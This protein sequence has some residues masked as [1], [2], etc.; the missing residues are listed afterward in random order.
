MKLKRAWLFS[1]FAL[2][3]TAFAAPAPLLKVVVASPT[4]PSN[5]YSNSCTLDANGQVIIEHTTTLFP[6]G[7]SL[8]SKEVRTASLSVKSIKA[9]IAEAAQGTITGTPIVGGYTHQYF[10]YQKQAGHTEE[11]FLLDRVGAGLFN[12]APVVE[13]LTKFIDSVCGDLSFVPYQETAIAKFSE[14][15]LDMAGVK[16]AIEVCAQTHA[17]FGVPGS[18]EACD[19]SGTGDRN[20]LIAMENIWDKISKTPRKDAKT[21]A[22]HIIQNDPTD[23]KHTTIIATAVNWNGLNGETYMLNGTYY[24]AGYII[25]TV[26]PASTCKTAGIC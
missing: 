9:V 16:A 22:V 18:P 19:G 24:P 4:T 8:K 3:G 20:V 11:I 12:D 23:P 21:A 14:V 25:W 13:P 26:D 1:L 6:S 15:I 7:P 2:S 5:S 10:A 17:G